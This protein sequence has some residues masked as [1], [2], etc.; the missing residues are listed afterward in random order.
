MEERREE[1]AQGSRS[2]S[3]WGSAAALGRRCSGR[4]EASHHKPIRGKEAIFRCG[5]RSLTRSRKGGR[6]REGRGKN[7]VSEKTKRGGMNEGRGRPAR[8]KMALK[9]DEDSKG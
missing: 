8:G 1:G 4:R 5:K 9:D 2:S 7:R 6:R 3:W